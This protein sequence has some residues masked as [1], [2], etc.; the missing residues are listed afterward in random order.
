[1]TISALS[2]RINMACGGTCQDA[3]HILWS[4]RCQPEFRSW[5]K[6]C[7]FLF[8]YSRNQCPAGYNVRSIRE[9]SALKPCSTSTC[10]RTHHHP[11]QP[12]NYPKGEGRWSRR[13]VSR[14]SPELK[15]G[16]S[17]PSL[18]IRCTG[19]R[20]V[21]RELAH[22]H[23]LEL[24]HRRETIHAKDTWWTDLPSC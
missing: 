20:V 6:S 21:S 9:P 16:A 19:K 4:S 12:P 2:V 5:C 14:S 15:S 1:M 7:W 24:V 8:V 22:D 13:V 17:R 23:R 11:Q 10:S 18:S 3:S